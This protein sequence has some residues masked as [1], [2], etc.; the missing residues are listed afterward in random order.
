MIGAR[1]EWWKVDASPWAAVCAHYARCAERR[2]GTVAALRAAVERME[3]A[4][5]TALETSHEEAPP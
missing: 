4:R 3:A 1:P 5:A 2:P